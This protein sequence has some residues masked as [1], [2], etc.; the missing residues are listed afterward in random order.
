MILWA[1]ITN[2]PGPHMA[3]GLDT[4]PLQ[5]VVRS[6]LM[7]TGTFQTILHKTD[8]MGKSILILTAV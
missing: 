8:F 3:H 6:S 2:C 4:S 7:C 5:E 1:P